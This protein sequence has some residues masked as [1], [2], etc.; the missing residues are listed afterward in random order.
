LGSQD[1]TAG[2]DLTTARPQ[3]AK[4]LQGNCEA[5]PDAFFFSD[6]FF[7][8]IAEPRPPWYTPWQRGKCKETSM[9]PAFNDDGYLPAGV[10]P[11][12]LDE[13]AARFGLEPELRR[14]QME[15]LRW[16]VD[17]AKRVGVQRV[18]V[19]GSF[20]TDKWEPN[21]IDCVLLRGPS[22]P[23]DESADAELW[24]GLPFIQIA[25]VGLTEFELYVEKIYATDRHGNSKGMV[26]VIV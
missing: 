16:L 21:D 10:H 24:S 13:I 2:S 3:G 11:A 5:T 17:L 7:F 1:N 19:N 22:F 23:L 14:V 15:S 6:P 8:S 9:I 26:E 12:T 18:I 25:L 20:V 4:S